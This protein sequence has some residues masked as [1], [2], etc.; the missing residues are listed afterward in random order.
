M[1]VLR[2][3]TVFLVLFG[4]ITDLSDAASAGDAAWE[5]IVALDAGP[6]AKARTG[7]EAR[8]AAI[9]H[10]GRQEEA[11]RGFLRNHESDP[12]TFEA[13]LRLAR[14]LQIRGDVQGSKKA[15]E[16]SS[17]LLDA[18][19]KIATVEQR[20]EVD[21]ARLTLQM[22]SLKAPTPRDRGQLLAAARRFQT[23]HPQ[24]RRLAALLAE[25][26]SLF[27]LQPKTMEALLRDA[28]SLPGDEELTQRIA[29]DL[30][31]IGLLGQPLSLRF[32]SVQGAPYEGADAAG[33]VVIVAFFAVWSQ[34][35]KAALD[36]VLRATSRLE[37]ER[38]KIVGVSLDTKLEPLAA[39]LL[40][41]G[42][43]WPVA[44]DGLGWE[45][46]LVRGVGVNALP[47]VWL[48]DKQGRLRSL[49]GL[50]S[51]ESQVRQLL[52]ER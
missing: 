28:A 30:K 39:Y 10:L 41:K 3:V 51:T 48:V 7:E 24:D 42:I 4:L 1:K 14:L 9:A 6:P 49:D 25:V 27:P 5:A 43:G 33:S 8:A 46:P 29:D 45:S 23:A 32:T 36:Q 11:L 35:S 26:A 31:K 13:R 22:R 19:S 18:L 15:V 21:F 12:H 40:E 2:C 20:A 37:K 52:N 44:C 17:E 47:T 34:P 50:E 38:V 16:E